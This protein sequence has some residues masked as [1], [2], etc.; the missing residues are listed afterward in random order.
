MAAEGGP[1]MPA[2]DPSGRTPVRSGDMDFVG[3]GVHMTDTV[4]Q[5]FLWGWDVML[6]SQF[7]LLIRC[8]LAVEGEGSRVQF[9]HST[10]NDWLTSDCLLYY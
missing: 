8:V 1:D 2:V 5:L 7:Q 4:K 3:S 6:L 9:F 10:C